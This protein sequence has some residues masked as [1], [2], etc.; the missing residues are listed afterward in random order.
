MPRPVTTML[1]WVWQTR[2]LARD[3]DRTTRAIEERLAIMAKA[4]EQQGQQ[5]QNREAAMQEMSSSLDGV[6]QELSNLQQTNP[7]VDVTTLEAAVS[8]A[9]SA[10][11]AARDA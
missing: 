3:I 8:R 1:R 6:R 2:E 4:Q 11:A 5:Q 9:E 7:G 10:A